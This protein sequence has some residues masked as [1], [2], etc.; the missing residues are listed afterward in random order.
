MAP[1]FGP[2]PKDRYSSRP[3]PKDFD[4]VIISWSGTGTH[5]A[6]GIHARGIQ[7][8]PS[9]SSVSNGAMRCDACARVAGDESYCARLSQ[10]L[11]RFARH[12]GRQHHHGA[13]RSAIFRRLCEDWLRCLRWLAHCR[14]DHDHEPVGT[15]WGVYYGGNG[16]K[17]QCELD[18]HVH[19]AQQRVSDSAWCVGYRHKGRLRD[20]RLHIHGSGSGDLQHLCR[21]QIPERLRWR[22]LGQLRAMR[23]LS[24][25]T[26]PHWM[27]RHIRRCMH[28]LRRWEIQDIL[29][30]RSLL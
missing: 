22:Q 28:L 18:V 14:C 7:S 24:S 8:R 13:N 12:H 11:E 1:V 23:W 15:Q 3:T 29:W 19:G 10:P 17:V 26:I 9:K 20:A 21:W 2:T 25:R 6:R 5:S 16:Q 27:Q 30:L 4:T